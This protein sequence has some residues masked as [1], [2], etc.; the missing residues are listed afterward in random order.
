MTALAKDPTKETNPVPGLSLRGP[1]LA[2]LIYKTPSLTSPTL[3]ALRNARTASVY[4]SS[5]NRSRIDV[6]LGLALACLTR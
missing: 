5:D 3:V 4:R 6:L 1:H 2:A